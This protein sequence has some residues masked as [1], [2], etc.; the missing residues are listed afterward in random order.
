MSESKNTDH[1]FDP[2]RDNT[3]DAVSDHQPASDTTDSF[4]EDAVIASYE[5]IPGDH[6]Y[7][8]YD[9][10][11]DTEEAADSDLLLEITSTQVYTDR[12]EAAPEP[13]GRKKRRFRWMKRAAALALSAALFGIFLQGT[14]I[15]TEPYLREWITGSAEKDNSI[16]L[17]PTDLLAIN[18]AVSTTTSYESQVEKVVEEVSPSIVSIT[19]TTRTRGY[20]NNILESDGAGSGIIVANNSDEILIA[21]NQHV[22]ASTVKLT[23]TFIDQSTAA[24]T[25]KGS[26]S[27]NDLAVVAVKVSDLS[28]ETLQAIRIA[29]LGDSDILKPGQLAIA[30]GNPLGYSHTMTGGY[31]SAINREVNI[32]GKVLTLIQTDAAINPGNSGGALVNIKGEVI[33]IN[34]VKFASTE[35]EGMGFAVPSNIARPILEELMKGNS[36]TVSTGKAYIGINGQDITSDIAEAYNMPI[37]IYIVG[38]IEDSPAYYSELNLGDVITAINGESITTMAELQT[39][40]TQYAPNDQI[41]LTVQRNSNRSTSTKDISLTLGDRPAD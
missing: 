13:P 27:A 17:N 33:G 29:T 5:I 26:D 1:E 4:P 9:A 39:E 8:K 32:D 22:V 40:L 16:T 38:I 14:L 24:G 12:A 31:I 15:Y 10:H 34:T 35:V 30:L 3:S 37:G 11:D 28:A 2:T 19:S 6:V 20:F 25:V 36:S 23:I 21:T 18:T 7:E 41:T